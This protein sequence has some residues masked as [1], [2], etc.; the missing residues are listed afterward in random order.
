MQGNGAIFDNYEIATDSLNF[1][2]RFT[3]GQ[4]TR[5]GWGNPG[6]FEKETLEV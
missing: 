6:D 3:T 2:E 4:P 5:A 1:Y